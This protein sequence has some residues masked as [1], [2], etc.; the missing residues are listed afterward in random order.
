[1][2]FLTS[3]SFSMGLLIMTSCSY[4]EVKTALANGGRTELGTQPQQPGLDF[5]AIKSQILT[6]PNSGKCSTCHGWVNNYADVKLKILEIQRRVNLPQGSL[7]AMPKDNSPI[8]LEQKE[9]LSRWISTGAPEFADSPT[10]PADTPPSDTPPDVPLEM[11]WESIS[12]NIIQ[13]YCVKCHTQADF[14]NDDTKLVTYEDVFRNRKD[15][16]KEVLKRDMPKDT[17][18]PDELLTALIEWIDLGA[19]LK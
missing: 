10:P 19:P 14:T 3:I 5:Q 12:K 2:R 9:L 8:T 13:P 15:I 17:R 4:H 16:R 6:N 18:L 7:G 11:N 1:M